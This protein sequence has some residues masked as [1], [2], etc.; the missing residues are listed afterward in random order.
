[1]FHF[2]PPTCEILENYIYDV[3]LFLLR[4]YI[5]SSTEEPSPSYNSNI[6]WQPVLETSSELHAKIDFMQKKEIV[7]K[8]NEISRN[9]IPNS[10][11][12]TVREGPVHPVFHLVI[13]SLDAMIHRTCL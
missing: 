7:N 10:T 3:F 9:S 1:M 4:Y 2:F 8:I 11:T 13:I 6:I 5:I 12:N